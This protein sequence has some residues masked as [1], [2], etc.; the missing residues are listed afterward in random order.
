MGRT[1]GQAIPGGEAAGLGDGKT[2]QGIRSD[3]DGLGLAR[4]R[5]SEETLHS[6]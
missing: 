6:K 5:E 4:G 1:S 3:R 2:V